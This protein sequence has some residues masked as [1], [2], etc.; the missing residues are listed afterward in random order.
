MVNPGEVASGGE[1]V[2]A[3]GGKYC[4]DARKRP[5]TVTTNIA[6]PLTVWQLSD[7]KR[8]HLRQCEGLL[9]AL[10]AH[11][12]IQHQLIEVSRHPSAAVLRLMLQPRREQLGQRRPDL[13][14][15]AGRACQWPML[16]AGRRYGGRTVYL[17]RPQLPTR[18]FDACIIPRH[19]QPADRP[20]IVISDGPLNPMRPAAQKSSSTRLILIGGPSAHHHWND[21]HMLKQIEQLIARQPQPQWIISDSRRTPR[22]FAQLL[23]S[24]FAGRAEYRP[25]AECA[26]DW[27]PS[28]L[29]QASVAWVSAD[30]VAMIYEAL[31]AGAEVGLLDVPMTKPDR[32]NAIGPALVARGWLD[33]LGQPA[34]QRPAPLN[35][36]ANCANALLE[37]WPELLDPQHADE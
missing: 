34:H 25:F 12:P 35:E 26:A 37:R 6:S 8:G 16:A 36:A 20:H 23:K 30:S 22:S 18:W 9:G 24:Q 28:T 33:T 14:I 1:L 2:D 3:S 32:I 19:D 29:A 11:C 13:I 10:A 7:G 17:M 31:S 5:P 4:A 21:Q 27:L 15:G